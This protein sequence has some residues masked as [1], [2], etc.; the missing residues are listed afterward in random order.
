[1]CH[2]ATFSCAAYSPS[3]P[4]LADSHA[5]TQLLVCEIAKDLHPHLTLYDVSFTII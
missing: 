2:T 1:M 5:H 4:R 3:V